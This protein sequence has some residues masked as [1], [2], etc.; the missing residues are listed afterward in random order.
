MSFIYIF[1]LSIYLSTY[2]Y[3]YLSICLTSY[4]SI[5]L[6]VYLH[7][8]F[9]LSVTC[10]KIYHHFPPYLYI[11]FPLSLS[12]YWYF[13]LYLVQGW[14]LVLC[15]PPHL[16]EVKNHDS[17][18]FSPQSPNVPKKSKTMLAPLPLDLPWSLYKLFMRP[19]SINIYIYNA[20]SVSTFT[21]SLFHIHFLRHW[22][23]S[24]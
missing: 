22:Y 21:F 6:S 5:Y 10:L 12:C 16:W 17:K 7:V 9:Y 19:L 18:G 23:F 3:I 1:Y 13:H 8:L 15:P 2:L 14:L 11:V 4:L 24:W 20:L